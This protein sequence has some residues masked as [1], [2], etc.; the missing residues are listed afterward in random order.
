MYGFKFFETSIYHNDKM[1]NT[2][3]IKNI[4]TQ[5]VRDLISFKA[6]E[7]DA[8]DSVTIKK[9]NISDSKIKENQGKGCSC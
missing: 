6:F 4:F 5:L 8:R 2:D 9:G 1:E 7:D 3:H